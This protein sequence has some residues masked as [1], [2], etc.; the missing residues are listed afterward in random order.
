MAVVATLL[1]MATVV[2]YMADV[3]TSIV[4]PLLISALATNSVLL[5]HGLVRLSMIYNGGFREI[6]I[7]GRAHI[8]AHIVPFG[9][10]LFL[11]FHIGGRWLDLAFLLPFATFFYTGRR[12]WKSLYG[13]FGNRMYRLYVL[14]N[15]GMLSAVFVTTI[16]DLSVRIEMDY[17]F[18][19]RL[20]LFYLAI[21]FLLVGLSVLRV[22]S[23]IQ[24]AQA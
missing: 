8:I 5:F 9:Y 12:M 24:R 21:H 11:Y 4:T 18:F 22:A 3:P 19:D 2:A 10:L 15:G 20:L 14:G 1:W 16:L 7:F 6:S 17:G 23:D 13:R